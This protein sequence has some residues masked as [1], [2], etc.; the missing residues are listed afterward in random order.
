MIIRLAKWEDI[1]QVA[2]IHIQEINRGF[3]TLLGEKF[4]KL[5][6]GAMVSSAG[7]FLI[8]AQSDD[9]RVIGFA[10]GSRDVR[11]LYSD[12]LKKYFLLILC[13]MLP[14]LFNVKVLSGIFDMIRYLFGKKD[15]N[16][17]RAE[18]LMLAVKK[19]F[20]NSGVATSL[21]QELI[22]QMK[23]LGVQEFKLIV[24]ESLTAAIKFH[25]SMGCRFHSRFVLHK[26]QPSRI[27]IYGIK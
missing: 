8:V 5:L 7:S 6:Y 19:E 24:G 10:S 21:F 3:L 15:P 4:L 17:P 27:Y 23:V 14:K 26:W 12:F 9:G 13:A 1:Q 20:R 22:K 2:K 18:F 16:L 11:K 25:E